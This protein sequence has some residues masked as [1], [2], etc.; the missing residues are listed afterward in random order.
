VFLTI[1]KSMCIVK[2]IFMV[3]DLLLIVAA[4]K[5]H[6]NEPAFQIFHW[7]LYHVCLAHILKPLKCGM[8]TLEVVHCPDSHFHYTIYGLG[9][10]IA[11][12][13]EQVWL[14]GI[15]QNWCPK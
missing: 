15:V 11:D 4:S 6:Q 1:P 13:S 8:T 3:S 2:V 12:Y 7:Q 10:Y 5:W 14:S 9:P